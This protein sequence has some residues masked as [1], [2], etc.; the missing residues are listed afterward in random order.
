MNP[1]VHVTHERMEMHPPLL[2]L[3]EERRV[4]ENV[5]QHRLAGADGAVEEHA[6]G[7]GRGGGERGERVDEEVG[8]EGG[9]H[10][11]DGGGGVAEG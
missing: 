7:E 1:F 9:G 4:V 8:G 10:G 5:H 3:R 11:G 2:R 6:A